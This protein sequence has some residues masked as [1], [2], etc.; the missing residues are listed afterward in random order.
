M[1]ALG[2]HRPPLQF[3]QPTNRICRSIKLVCVGPVTIRS[4]VA[5]RKFHESLLRRNC[6][7]T[8]PSSIAREQ[9]NGSTS[10]PAADVGP[11]LPSV[12]TLAKHDGVAEGRAAIA[13][14]QANV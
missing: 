7:G 8:S 12:A 9:V 2:G 4:P 5:L 10:P 6:A 14:A 1:S 13:M 11:S 3:R